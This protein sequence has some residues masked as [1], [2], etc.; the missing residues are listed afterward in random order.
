MQGGDDEEIKG[1]AVPASGKVP[2]LFEK[3]ESDNKGYN[4]GKSQRVKE[5]PMSIKT[6]E[7]YTKPGQDDIEIR[8]HRAYDG[9]NPKP[10]GHVFE[11]RQLPG[12]ETGDGMSKYRRHGPL[13]YGKVMD[14]D[15]Y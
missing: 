10:G 5:T 8:N 7:R 1:Q 12:G 15:K 9:E 13:I 11:K 3:N 14:I 6:L 4:Q 2:L